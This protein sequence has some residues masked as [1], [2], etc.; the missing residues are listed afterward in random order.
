L[1]AGFT[2]IEL[3]VLIAPPL[4]T[5]EGAW[6][7]TLR[8]VSVKTAGSNSFHR[9]A[10]RVRVLSSFVECIAHGSTARMLPSEG[11]PPRLLTVDGGSPPGA[12]DGRVTHGFGR[13]A[14]PILT[15]I[16]RDP[17]SVLLVPAL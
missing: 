2:L 11:S 3:L 6:L 15:T 5:R 13:V 1:I 17:Q 10:W 16:G 7:G 8:R 12:Q 14:R 9:G 4:C